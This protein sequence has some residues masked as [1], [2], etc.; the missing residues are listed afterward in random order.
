M[1]HDD[2][3]C[4]VSFPAGLWALEHFKQTTF[5]VGSLS[6]LEA[7]ASEVMV[8]I[9][10]RQGELYWRRVGCPGR[11]HAPHL[12]RNLRQWCEQ[13]RFA[14]LATWH[15][16]LAHYAAEGISPGRYSKDVIR[17]ARGHAR[18]AARGRPWVK[19]R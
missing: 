6:L 7:P 4:P 1:A 14:A 15:T 18:N 13:H 9:A 5:P 10:R 11:D 3:L 8:R 2:E 19:Q 12:Y 17:R 16:A